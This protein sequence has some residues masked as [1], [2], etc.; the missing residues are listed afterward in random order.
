VRRCQWALARPA[1]FDFAQ[2]AGIPDAGIP[3]ASF[4]PSPK[5]CSANR[6]CTSPFPCS[7]LPHSHLPRPRRPLPHLSDPTFIARYNDLDETFVVEGLLVE[8]PE[9]R[10]DSTALLL[11]IERIRPESAADFSPVRGR[12][13]ARISPEEAWRYEE[14]RYG[15]R[16][17]LAG[18]VE[19]PPE[20]ESGSYR[21]F[22]AR[23]GIYSLMQRARKRPTARQAPPTSSPSAVST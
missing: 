20:G 21:D 1:S 3:D 9:E 22:L 14:L 2:D 23:Q 13:L 15:D 4:S 11:Q 17:R 7:P 6:V 18:R 8:P 16:L 10:D 5:R 12:L 19:T